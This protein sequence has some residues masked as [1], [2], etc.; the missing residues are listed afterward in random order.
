MKILIFVFVLFALGFVVFSML[1]KRELAL[2]VSDDGDDSWPYHVKKLL[3]IL[4][5]R[6]ITV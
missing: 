3:L 2:V 4:S 1:K 6:F 5:R